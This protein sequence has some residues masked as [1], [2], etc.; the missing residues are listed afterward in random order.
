MWPDRGRTAYFRYKSA[1]NEWQH[2]YL[3]QSGWPEN[4]LS[5]SHQPSLFQL[6]DGME[7]A[8]ITFSYES[9]ELRQ[10]TNVYITVLPTGSLLAMDYSHPNIYDFDIGFQCY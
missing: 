9:D 5:V 7:A 3:D 10:S 4:R 6:N 2:Y 8:R 1:L